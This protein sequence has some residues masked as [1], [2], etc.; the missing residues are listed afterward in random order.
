MENRDQVGNPSDAEDASGPQNSLIDISRSRDLYST[1]ADWRVAI[2]KP[3]K[4]DKFP[5]RRRIDAE[6]HARCEETVEA[7][8]SMSSRYVTC[9]L[10]SKK[11]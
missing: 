10:N 9:G 7:R 2:A 8:I 5:G 6:T 3:I 11:K 1:F 4:V